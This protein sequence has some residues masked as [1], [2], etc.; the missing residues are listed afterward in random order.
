MLGSPRGANFRVLIIDGTIWESTWASKYHT[1]PT[2]SMHAV[3]CVVVD[4]LSANRYIAI[5]R[6][7]RGLKSGRVRRQVES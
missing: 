1:G 3:A 4:R 5:L 6:T 2:V 7:R